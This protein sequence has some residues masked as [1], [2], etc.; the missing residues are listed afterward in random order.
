M[1]NTKWFKNE[2]KM[3]TLS[4]LAIFLIDPPVEEKITLRG[5]ITKKRKKLGQC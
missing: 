5:A 3:V 1:I 4:N 2:N